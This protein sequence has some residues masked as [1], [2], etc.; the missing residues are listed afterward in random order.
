MTFPTTIDI[1]RS[2]TELDLQGGWM[3]IYFAHTF[4]PL[5]GMIHSSNDQQR[6]EYVP[7]RRS[8]RA[9]AD[10]RP[11]LSPTAIRHSKAQACSL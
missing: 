4:P 5:A 1:S 3:E 9:T 8:R 6:D 11:R 2:Q 10:G 7:E